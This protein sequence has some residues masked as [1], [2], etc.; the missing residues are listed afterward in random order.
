MR[1][2]PE[3]ALETIAAAAEA[4][5]TVF[6]TA[7]AY[8][9]NEQRLARALRRCGMAERARIVTKGGMARPGG[10]WV[11]DGRAKAIRADCEASLDALDGLPIDLY[12]LHAPDPRTPLKTSV[13]ALARLVG[14]GLVRRVG[15]A[16][17]NRGQLD[18]ALEL[19]PVAAVQVALSPFDDRALRGGVV[20]R[21][22]GAR[23]RADRALAARRT[24]AG[25][26]DR[27]VGD[28]LV[29]ARPF[30]RRRP[31]PRRPP[32]GDGARCRACGGNGVS[33]SAAP[34]PPRE[35]DDAGRCRGCPRDGRS[36]RREEPRRGRLHGARL[37]PAQP[38][39]AR[40]VA[41]RPRRGPRRGAD[42]RR[43]PDRARQHLPHACGTERGD[44]GR[45]PA[46]DPGPVHLA[47]D[48]ARPGTGQPR[49]APAR[50]ARFVA[51]PRA[52]ARAGAA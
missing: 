26:A 42:R 48:A 11:P 4:G 22:D 12:L 9:G 18:E 28:A 21:C 37:P 35:A 20:D 2:P 44:R 30:A 34:A 1:L 38:R 5:I 49:R 17:V 7:R 36:R 41:A 45:R 33:A 3:S 47:R 8:D 39:R 14:E 31:D 10:A 16:N 24:E 25:R 52:A 15:L 27:R 32:S 13:R 40:R 19:A 46:R 43:A 50:A 23:D 29:A 51:G 6:D